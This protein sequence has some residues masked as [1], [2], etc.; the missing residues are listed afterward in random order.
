MFNGVV[1]MTCI[2]AVVLGKVQGVFY[3]NETR[4][5]A[6]SLNITGWVKNNDDGSVELIACGEKENIDKLIDWLWQGPKRANVTNVLH[7]VV[8]IEK[9]DG[10]VIL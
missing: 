3:R 4:K 9:Q 6:L 8:G 1:M 10:F 5:K 7:T 2:K